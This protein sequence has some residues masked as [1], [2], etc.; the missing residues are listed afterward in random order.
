[1]VTL[2]VEN[3]EA[4]PPMG[5][6]G[7]VEGAGPMITWLVRR[8]LQA[9]FVVVAMT[10]IVFVGVHVVQRKRAGVAH[11]LGVLRSERTDRRWAGSERSRTSR[12]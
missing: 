5:R 11:R 7:F 1:M 3:G 8:L 2:T 4:A 6:C 10:V 9:A 12:H